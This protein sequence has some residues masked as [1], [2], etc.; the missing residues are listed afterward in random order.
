MGRDSDSYDSDDERFSRYAAGNMGSFRD[1]KAKFTISRQTV[2][3]E[4]SE[5]FLTVF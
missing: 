5:E 4:V 1:N 3:D 2:V